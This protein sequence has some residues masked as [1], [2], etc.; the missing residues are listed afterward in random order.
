M[1]KSIRL[2]KVHMKSYQTGYLHVH[3]LFIRTDECIIVHP[4]LFRNKEHNY[5]LVLTYEIPR[6][7]VYVDEPKEETVR[8]TSVLSHKDLEMKPKMKH[9]KVHFYSNNT[10]PERREAK[11]H[12]DLE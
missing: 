11:S 7:N 8:H 1:P 12:P 5:M 10:A 6:N 2:Y 9:T 4:K 3:L